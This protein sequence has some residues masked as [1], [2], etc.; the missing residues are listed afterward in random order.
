M[1]PTK[2]L[3]GPW[4]PWPPY[5]APHATRTLNYFFPSWLVKSTFNE[6]M[7]L[8]VPDYQIYT[9]FASLRELD[10]KDGFF[11]AVVKVVL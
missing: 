1:P 2:L 4:P 6:C 8:A 3:E 5:R 11:F 7:S 10:S 9:F